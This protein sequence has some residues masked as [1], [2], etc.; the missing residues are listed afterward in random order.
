MCLF[1]TKGASVAPVCSEEDEL[2]PEKFI[3]YQCCAL[4]HRLTHQ[5]NCYK[6]H[7]EGLVELIHSSIGRLLCALDIL[8]EHELLIRNLS[9]K[10]L[11][12]FVLI[13]VV[14]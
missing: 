1:S 2:Y 9:P 6:T 13:C 12:F 8:F 10:V 7:L 11:C 4:F 14:L 3:P 5:L